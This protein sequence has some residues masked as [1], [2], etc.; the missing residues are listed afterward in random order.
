MP[1]LVITGLAVAVIGGT[2]SG[3]LDLSTTATQ[4]LMIG[5]VIAGAPVALGVR[6]HDIH[7]R[8]NRS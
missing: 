3:V 1:R 8:L 6:L 4:Y 5:S 7:A 2:I